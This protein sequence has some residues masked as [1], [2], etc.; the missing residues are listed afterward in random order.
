M[1]VKCVFDV[2]EKTIPEKYTFV[3][4]F[5][6]QVTNFEVSKVIVLS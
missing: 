1:D 5:D 3:M 6:M 4:E 2:Q